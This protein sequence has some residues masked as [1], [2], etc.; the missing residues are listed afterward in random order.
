ML[1]IV[2]VVVV[3]GIKHIKVNF[4]EKSHAKPAHLTDEETKAPES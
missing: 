1:Q 2:V 4:L 3:N